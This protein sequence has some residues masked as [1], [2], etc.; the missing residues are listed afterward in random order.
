MSHFLSKS[1]ELVKINKKI[2]YCEDCKHM[3]ENK[4]QSFIG[5]ELCKLVHSDRVSKER[6]SLQP[7][8]FINKIGDCSL[9]EEK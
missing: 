5:E 6:P 2:S 9:F 1:G 3:G 4:T 8:R 7:C